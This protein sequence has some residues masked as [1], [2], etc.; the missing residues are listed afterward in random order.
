MNEPFFTLSSNEI[1]LSFITGGLFLIQLLYHI[2]VYARPLKEAQKRKNDR[3]TSTHKEYKAVSIVVYANGDIDNL[4]KNLPLLLNQ[5]Y[6]QFE[7]IVVNDG[8]DDESE[9][10]LKRF[11]IENKHLYYRLME[12]LSY[13]ED[14]KRQISLTTAMYLQT[15]VENLCFKMILK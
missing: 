5:N 14:A 2:I 11:S 15:V 9:N 10:I 3:S 12:D 13:V 8:F 1:I 4:Q 7:V 6:P